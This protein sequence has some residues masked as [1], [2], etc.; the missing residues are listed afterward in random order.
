M[1]SQ[2]NGSPTIMYVFISVMAKMK[3]QLK[4]EKPSITPVEVN[5]E[6]Q[7]DFLQ[8][9]AKIPA[10]NINPV[11]VNY[12]KDIV[13]NTIKSKTLSIPMLSVPNKTNSL[14]TQY[15]YVEIGSLHNALLPIAMDYLQ[16]LGTDKY[17][18]DEISQAFY[19][20]A[21]DFGVNAGQEESYVYLNGLETT[22]K[23]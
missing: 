8:K 6:A 22:K 19:N 10:K 1:T 14:F 5:R 21:C 4:I 3:T 9:I 13:R 17:N 11:F 16:Y 2:K 20:L 23:G 15:Y 7:S 18:A 12:Q